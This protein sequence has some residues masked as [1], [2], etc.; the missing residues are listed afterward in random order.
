MTEET[1][2]VILDQ[3]IYELDNEPPKDAGGYPA[4]E[5]HERVGAKWAEWDRVVTG[6][7]LALANHLVNEAIEDRRGNDGVYEDQA[8]RLRLNGEQA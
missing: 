1:F 2:E 3:L 5:M 6:L 8:N 4:I 7:R